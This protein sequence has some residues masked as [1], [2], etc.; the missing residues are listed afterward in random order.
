MSTPTAFLL[1]TLEILADSALIDLAISFAKFIIFF[2]CTPGA[3]SSSYNVTTG[4]GIIPTTLAS[5]L[6]SL[7]TFSNNFAFCWS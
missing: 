5:I 7:I 6:N 2:I 3:G 4:P 1:R